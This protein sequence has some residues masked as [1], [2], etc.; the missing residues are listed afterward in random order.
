MDSA[1]RA[2]DDAVSELERRRAELSDS[3]RAGFLDQARPVIDTI[4]Q[5]HLRRSDTL[6]ALDFLEGMRARVLLERIRG[7]PS[8]VGGPR[9]RV[10]ALR[11]VIP[12]STTIVSYALMDRTLVAWLIRRNS[13]T[14]YRTALTE[15]IEPLVDRFQE[16]LS[17]PSDEA[18][19]RA[20]STRL[21][22]LLVGPFQ[23][24]LTPE[25]RLVFVPDKRL[26]FVPFAALFDQRASRFL[27]ESFEIG[28]APS[29]ELYAASLARFDSVRST[30]PTTVLAV[31]NPAFD[32]RVFRLP[33]LPG[34]EREAARVAEAYPS[35][36]LL[37]DSGATAR[38]FF[39]AARNVDVIHF[40]GHG[41]VRPEAPLQSHLVLAPD[42]RV[43]SSGQIYA[44]SLYD[45]S[46]AHTRLAILSGCHTA[47]GELSDTE[48]VSSLARALF[49]AGVPAVIA[50]LWALDDEQTAEFFAEFHRGVVRGVNPTTLLR[51]AELRW[52]R[53]GGNPWRNMS[54]WAAF[55]LFGASS[56][57][58]GS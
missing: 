7:A 27:I 25:T 39:D 28:V 45:A 37:V 54:M 20:V 50:S 11:R 44:R 12:P 19:L 26:Q 33:R 36:R 29:V 9:G 3:A 55:E 46:F 18:E 38:R 35:A 17:G 31:G 40:A 14:M 53:K 41:I 5:F 21:H 32:A 24:T 49:A 48:G 15:P 1:Q 13:V 52:I 22:Q 2:F 56:S 58:G 47:G 10:A 6:G 8:N 43:N 57:S 34:A 42:P 4:L 16:L 51:Q 30:A 23:Q